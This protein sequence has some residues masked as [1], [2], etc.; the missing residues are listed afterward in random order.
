MSKQLTLILSFVV[1]FFSAC[2]FGGA[3]PL[4]ES[5]DKN[6]LINIEGKDVSTYLIGEY[7]APSEAVEKLEE[8]GFDVIGSYKPVKDGLCIVFTNDELKQEA[9]EP[10]RAYAA[11]LRL[12]IDKQE[13]TISFTNPIY[14]GKAFMQDDYDHDV[15]NE[16]LASI[17]EEFSDLLPSKDRMNFDK[18]SNY[19]FMMGMPYYKDVDL[20]GKKAINNEKIIEKAETY[21]KGKG[22]VFKLILS[23]NSTLIGFK[24]TKRSKKFVSKVGRANG[25]VLPYCIAVENGQAMALNAKYYIALSYP[26]LDMA[27]FMSIATVPGAITKELEKPFK[28]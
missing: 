1:L 18:L 20:L 8:A 2:S 23:E 3:T 27:G 4:D 21:R 10:G 16:V 14:F 25:S 19:H 15:F 28:K 12:F 5:E 24:L 13:Q 6:A 22:V 26:L 11:V 7:I 9:S 17:N